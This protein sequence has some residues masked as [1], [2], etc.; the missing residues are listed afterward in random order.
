MFESGPGTTPATGNIVGHV[1][2]LPRVRSPQLRNTRDIQVYLPPSY[3]ASGRHYPVIYMHDGQNLFDPELSFAG[4]WGV[5]ETMERLAPVGF[6]GIVVAIPNMGGERAHEYSPWV[7][8]RGGGGKGDAYLDF[9]TDTLKPQIDGRFRTL[10]DREHTGIV[11]SSMGGLISLYGFLRAPGVFGF[12]GAMSPSLWF[13]NRA[14]FEYAAGI[15]RWFGRGAAA[16]TQHTEHVPPAAQEVPPPTGPDHLYRRGGRPAHG[17]GLG[18]A[19]RAGRAIPVPEEEAGCEL[20]TSVLPQRT[21]RMN[22]VAPLA[23][24]CLLA[25]GCADTDPSGTSPTGAAAVL[26]ALAGT[27][28][29]GSSSA[30]LPAGCTALEYTVTPGSD[31]DSGAVAFSG[32]CSGVEGSGSGKAAVSGSTLNWSAEGTATRSGLSCPFNFNEGTAALEGSGVRVTFAGTVCGVP[33]S[34]SELLQRK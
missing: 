17:A 6:E 1:R 14:M 18:A 27:W 3:K 23:I 30:S 29:L 32:V 24:A 13:A 5:D 21:I 16:R 15:E 7:D 2:V 25:A 12:C 8:P 34:G 4:E 26:Q 9:I 33:V 11:G 22:R 20:V 19:V 31:G 10:R 28:T